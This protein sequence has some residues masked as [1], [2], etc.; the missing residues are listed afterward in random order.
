MQRLK[1]NNSG[2]NLQLSDQ[3]LLLT[4]GRNPGRT[5]LSFTRIHIECDGFA[6]RSIH[7]LQPHLSS[8]WHCHLQLTQ[9]NLGV[10]RE[11]LNA[12]AVALAEFEVSDN[13]NS[14]YRCIDFALGS[15]VVKLRMEDVNAAP[16]FYVP[17][18]EAAW[19]AI[20]DIFPASTSA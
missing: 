17:S 4:W 15:E 3:D 5:G 2:A 12:A 18:F 13:P 6:E 19:A 10:I 8:F 14:V 16:L 11:L 1:Q 20:M 7:E 9:E